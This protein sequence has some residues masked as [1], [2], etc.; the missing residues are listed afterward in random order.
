[1]LSWTYILV[2]NSAQRCTAS[3]CVFVP[4]L[5][6]LGLLLRFFFL[7]LLGFTGYEHL[8]VVWRAKGGPVFVKVVFLGQTALH[9]AVF[10][11]L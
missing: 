11:L 5:Q 8:F 7:L 2:L 1:M 9:G 4:D 10:H 6:V 3:R